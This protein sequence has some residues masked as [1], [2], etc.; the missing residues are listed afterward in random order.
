MLYTQCSP[1]R[2]AKVKRKRENALAK[3][4]TNTFGALRR[5]Y[6]FPRK[7]VLGAGRAWSKWT[8]P[9]LLAEGAYL[10]TCYGAQR[11]KPAMSGSEAEHRRGRPEGKAG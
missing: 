5:M 2:F 6:G 8:A 10:A 9:D 3:G 1:T 4:T 11:R 7:R